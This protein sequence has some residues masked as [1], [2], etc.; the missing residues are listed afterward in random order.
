MEKEEVPLNADARKEANAGIHVKILQIEAELAEEGSK[1]PLVVD[2]IIYP[3]R[4][5][6]DLNEVSSGQINHEDDVFVLLAD[7]AA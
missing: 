6:K 5:G 2:V 1:W 7:E 3:Q 4:Q